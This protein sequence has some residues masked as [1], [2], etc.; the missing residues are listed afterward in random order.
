MAKEHQNRFN[1][2][3]P[4]YTIRYLPHGFTTPKHMLCLAMKDPRLIFDAA[5]RFTSFST[6]IN[7]M[8]STHLGTELNC[9]YGD[10]LLQ[11]YE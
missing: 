8:T 10:V 7:M 5:K 2:P 4:Y 1:M 11:L 9:L 3:L 6:P